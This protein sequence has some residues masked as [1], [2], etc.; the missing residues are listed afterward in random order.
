MS[1][2]IAVDD[3]PALIFSTPSMVDFYNYMTCFSNS[4]SDWF[5]F[6]QTPKSPLFGLSA[7]LLLFGSYDRVLP[8]YTSPFGQIL[9][10][11]FI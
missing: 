7:R 6:G 9:E 5:Q 2:N 3:R 1:R 4:G 10:H 11:W 8:C